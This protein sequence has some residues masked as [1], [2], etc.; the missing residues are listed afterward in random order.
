M[1]ARNRL[2]AVAAAAV[3]LTACGGD[4]ETI[5]TVAE[6]GTA[7]TTAPATVPVTS[8]P[9]IAAVTTA[10]ATTVA[11]TAVPPA[12]TVATPVSATGAPATTAAPTAGGKWQDPG[13]VFAVAFPAEPSTQNLQAPLP[14]G[15]SLPVTAYLAEVDGAAAIASCVVYPEGSVIDPTPV[16]ESARDGAL[17]NVGAELVDSQPI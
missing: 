15:T 1:S 17:T 4:D 10:P 3:A 13:G 5:D 7:S 11:A 16:L 2:A 9:T 14:D 12:T 8:V 6:S